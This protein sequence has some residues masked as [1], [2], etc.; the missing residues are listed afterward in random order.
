M[1]SIT[2]NKKRVP[3]LSLLINCISA[4][5]APQIFSIK[6]ECPFR[7]SNF[8]IIGL[9]NSLANSWFDIISL[10]TSTPEAFYLK[11]YKPLKQDPF[12]INH[13]LDF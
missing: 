10:L 6:D 2:H 5:S 7:F 3:L 8:L 4:K 11:V 13:I 12:D 1:L 9:C